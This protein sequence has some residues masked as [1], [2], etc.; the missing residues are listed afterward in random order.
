M[1]SERLR[2][3][4]FTAT[5]ENNYVSPRG[6][7]LRKVFCSTAHSAFSNIYGLLSFFSFR[8]FW[9]FPVNK[10]PDVDFGGSSGNVP[11]VPPAHIPAH[12]CPPLKKS[13]EFRC[14]WWSVTRSQ[15]TFLLHVCRWTPLSPSRYAR[16]FEAASVSSAHMCSHRW[17]PQD[18]TTSTCCGN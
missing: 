5:R 2:F 4:C 12:T 14:L 6:K 9:Y 3:E 8:T 1:H 16:T 15:G 18:H 17:L 11:T 10:H 13:H 7:V